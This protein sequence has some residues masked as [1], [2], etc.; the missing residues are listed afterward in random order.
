MPEHD[1]TEHDPTEHDCIVAG[2]DGSPASRAAVSYAVRRAR[3]GRRVVVVHTF[4]SP[5]ERFGEPNAQRLLDAEL[6]RARARIDRLQEEVPELGQVDWT[7]EVLVGPAAKALAS[8]A[9][10]E[11]AAEIAIGTRGLGR[12]RALLGSTAHDLLHIARCPVVVIPERAVTELAGIG[13]RAESA[14]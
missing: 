14:A 3:G 2:F 7:P 9:A 5:S 6:A 8:V 13:G 10:S 12:A 1:P 11:R 4:T